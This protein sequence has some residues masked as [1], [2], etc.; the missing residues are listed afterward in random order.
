MSTNSRIGILHRDGTTE[1][2]RCHWDGYP[3]HQMP[4]LTGHYDTA[5]K[6]RAL[7]ELGDISILGERLAPDTDEPHS[8]Q[9]PVDGV[10]V[11]YHRDRNE[12]PQSPISHRSV[13]EL[14]NS[15]WSID[16]FYLFDE[17]NGEWLPPIK[18]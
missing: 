9:K 12:P 18:G 3:E 6:V 10:T 1:T 11:A 13:E 16:W 7:L 2:I 4:I 8:F 14:K 17:E 15:D 5:E